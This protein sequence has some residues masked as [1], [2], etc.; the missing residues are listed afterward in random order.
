MCHPGSLSQLI[1]VAGFFCQCTAIYCESSPPS[2]LSNCFGFEAGEIESTCKRTHRHTLTHGRAHSDSFGFL[3][4]CKRLEHSGKAFKLQP[5]ITARATLAFL[6]ALVTVKEKKNN[7]VCTSCESGDPV[8]Q[9]LAYLSSE[10]I[11][12]I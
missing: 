3:A 10:Q 7:K 4:E 9:N 1:F 12:W 8:T 6:S 5:V 2:G 11:T